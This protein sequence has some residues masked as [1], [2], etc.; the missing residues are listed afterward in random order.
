MLTQF[1]HRKQKKSKFLKIIREY[2][3]EIDIQIE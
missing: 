1:L 2:I 3:T